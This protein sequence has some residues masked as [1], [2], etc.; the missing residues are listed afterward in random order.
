MM[1]RYSGCRAGIPPILHVYSVSDH[2]QIRPPV[3]EPVAVDV[4][5]FEPCGW[6][7]HDEVMKSDGSG[8]RITLN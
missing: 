1:S 4:I 8:R 3:V 5:D 7:P 6:L 2:P